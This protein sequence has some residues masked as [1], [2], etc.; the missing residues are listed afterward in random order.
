VVRIIFSVLIFF[1][2]YFDLF[3]VKVQLLFKCGGG[4]HL[5]VDIGLLVVIYRYESGFDCNLLKIVLMIMVLV[6]VHI[7]RRSHFC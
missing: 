4:L 1:F 7:A 5:V 3:Q 6:Y 2:H